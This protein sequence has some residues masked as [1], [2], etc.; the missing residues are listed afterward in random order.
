MSHYL[1]LPIGDKARGKELLT[2]CKVRLDRPLDSLEGLG[3]ALRLETVDR[4]PFFVP[5]ERAKTG[6]GWQ[7]V[8]IKQSILRR[9]DLVLIIYYT[10]QPKVTKLFFSMMS[11]T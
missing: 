2:W 3:L 5:A 11:S 7:L 6:T 8:R 4:E 1:V 9:F 10:L